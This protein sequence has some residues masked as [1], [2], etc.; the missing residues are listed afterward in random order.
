MDLELGAGFEL[1]LTAMADVLGRSDGAEASIDVARRWFVGDRRGVLVP[2]LGV[3]WQSRDLV[4]Y[5]YGVRPEEALADRP[6][7]SG[8][9]AVS[10]RAGVL[11][12]WRLG[13]RVSATV[14]ARVQLLADE[15]HSSPI[16][17]RRWT[18]FELAG[19]TYRF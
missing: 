16:V 8:R 13:P 6:R 12:S 9:S 3:V 10:P 11:V 18:H 5:Y 1:D 19:L 14:M 4:D 17:G 7:Y 15:I 2:S